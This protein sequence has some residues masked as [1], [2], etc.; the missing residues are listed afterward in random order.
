MNYKLWK[1]VKGNKPTTKIEITEGCMVTDGSYA[2]GE[3]SIAC[4]ELVSLCL[5][6]TNVTLSVNYTQI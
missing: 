2:Y 6:E 1:V 5:P 3:H 4:G